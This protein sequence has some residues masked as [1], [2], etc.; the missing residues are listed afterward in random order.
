MR[1]CVCM[2]SVFNRC[3]HCAYTTATNI[4][5]CLL[6]SLICFSH[7]HHLTII[8]HF[9]SLLLISC[10]A[11]SNWGDKQFFCLLDWVSSSAW[12]E[13]KVKKSFSIYCTTHDNKSNSSS[14][15]N[16]AY[17]TP[18]RQLYLKMKYIH[19]HHIACAIKRKIDVTLMCQLAIV[20]EEN[21]GLF[22][23]KCVGLN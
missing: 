22:R 11:P 6:H 1:V 5:I 23:L 12:N 16:I 14:S 18:S 7:H 4:S 21:V 2:C 8:I 13:L 9:C 19:H 10:T 20:I 15:R 3:F 17:Q